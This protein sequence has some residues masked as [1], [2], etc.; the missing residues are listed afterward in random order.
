MGSGRFFDLLLLGFLGKLQ[1]VVVPSGKRRSYVNERLEGKV[2]RKRPAGLLSVLF[3][4]RRLFFLGL[5][6]LMAF[7]ISI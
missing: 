7:A 6:M 2:S 1:N 3:G 5:M 4:K